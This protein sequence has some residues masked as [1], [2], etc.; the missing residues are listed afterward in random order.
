MLKWVLGSILGP[1]MAST[2]G[3]KGVQKGSKME[4]KLDQDVMLFLNAFWI[5]LDRFW[6]QL[7]SILASKMGFKSVQKG[8]QK[9]SDEKVKMVLPLKREHRFHFFRGV[10]RSD[11]PVIT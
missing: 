1:N 9:Q 5:H 2:W 7:G 4:A 6:S 8:A 3:P 11:E 10:K